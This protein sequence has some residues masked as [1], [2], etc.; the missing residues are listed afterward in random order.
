MLYSIV[1][2]FL[3][4]CITSADSYGDSNFGYWKIDNNTN[5][6]SYVY[7]GHVNASELP[8]G[9]APL[10]PSIVHHVGNDKFVGLAITNGE[11]GI[12]QD[13]GGAKIIGCYSA[14]DKQYRGG[15]GY[16]VDTEAH[17]VVAT[18]RANESITPQDNFYL[19]FGMGFMKKKVTSVDGTVAVNQT[20]TV[21]FGEN[22][23]MESRVTITD[24]RTNE[25]EGEKQYTW[26]E[27]WGQLR[28]DF[29]MQECSYDYVPS[30]E[31]VRD[32]ENNVIGII[33]RP[34]NNNSHCQGGDVNKPS[35]E[36]CNPRPTY[37]LAVSDKPT[38]YT[39]SSDSIF[40]HTNNPVAPTGVLGPLNN[41]SN[42]TA[43]DA[44]FALQ[45][46]FSLSPGESLS[47]SFMIGYFVQ[48]QE[49]IDDM[50]VDSIRQQLLESETASL[51]S[52]FTSQFSVTADQIGDHM[53]RELQWHA[54][55]IRAGLSFDTFYNES[56]LNQAGNYL[57]E[58]GMQGAAR[59]PLGHVMP[60]I[61]ADVSNGASFVKDIVRYTLKEIRNDPRTGIPG[62][63]PWG[64][65]AFGME[66]SLN[67][68]PSDLE[69]NMILTAA[70]YVLAQRDVDFLNEM[71]K[72]VNSTEDTVFNLLWL[73]FT[74]LRQ[75]TGIQQDTGL[76]TLLNVD[77][78]DGLLDHL[79]PKNFSEAQFYGS[80]VMNT[81]LGAF[82]ADQFAS[83]M[84]LMGPGYEDKVN[85]TLAWRDLLKQGV[86]KSWDTAW[87]K[88]VYIGETNGGWI[89]SYNNGS[90]N[91]WTETQSWSILAD[92][93]PA[94]ID[95]LIKRLNDTVRTPSP[96]GALNAANANGTGD[97][98]GVWYC[99]NLALI[100]GLARYGYVDMALE[101][102]DKNLFAAHAEK[103]PD[104]YFG[105]WSGPDT[106]SSVL[107]G[108]PGS[109]RSMTIGFP[110]L[111]MWAHTTPLFSITSI[112]GTTF[113]E[114]GVIFRPKF[115]KYSNVN[116]STPLVGFSYL[117]PCCQFE[118][119]YNPAQSGNI[120]VRFDV[121]TETMACCKSKAI[122]SV[123]GQQVDPKFN[124]MIEVFGVGG[125]D[126]DLVF[127]AEHK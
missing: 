126:A 57:Y 116:M 50:Q 27:L 119:R 18:S 65:A 81:A 46:T 55:N 4:L 35:F 94:R 127:K 3:L 122:F 82:M 118:G 39:T 91:M 52:H 28:T 2:P 74:H 32:S 53:K 72:P 1:L 48:G 83:M 109:T 98:A 59:D 22:A 16:L 79:K 25:N 89:G 90:G 125:Y 42:T 113:D 108:D 60:L 66:Y 101:E 92:V 69:N 117:G 107:V 6:P 73:C 62:W 76:I 87:Y 21:P 8:K 71:V 54:Y 95:G 56:M 12:R 80:S 75:S 44:T 61:F 43:G 96:V 17:K 78:N 70:Q 47:L 10:V 85:E 68:W 123:N 124:E 110:V 99:G 11:F 112:L 19:E 88:R 40:Q 121:D 29:K 30:F 49:A 67:F 31:L 9:Y 23:F 34:N 45:H 15:F 5:L 26:T 7:T 58:S 84:K 102:L 63:I 14:K 105:V 97:Y 51:W 38:S 106:Y 114:L 64:Q 103:Y 37:I 86:D 20:L 111:N 104:I 77:H 115:S 120:S 33:N 100:A 36:D 41:V 24:L 93:T 13:E